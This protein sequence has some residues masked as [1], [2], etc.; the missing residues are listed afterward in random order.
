MFQLGKIMRLISGQD[1]KIRSAEIQLPSKNTVS[2]SV[3]YLYPLELQVQL[4]EKSN[5]G[6][7]KCCHND[8]FAETDIGKQKLIVRLLTNLDVEKHFWKLNEPYI[9]V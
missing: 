6:L 8:D 9:T 3:N 4:G 7:T 5:K 1:S 2:R